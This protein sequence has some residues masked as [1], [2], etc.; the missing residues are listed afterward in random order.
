MA[1]TE[2][3]GLG[4]GDRHFRTLAAPGP[5]VSKGLDR[6]TRKGIVPRP[7]RPY[8]H[9]TRKGIVPCPNRPYKHWT[10]K[11]HFTRPKRPYKH[12]TRTGHFTRSSRPYKHWTRTGQ[13]LK[14]SD[15]LGDM[16]TTGWVTDTQQAGSQIQH[17]LCQRYTTGR[18]RG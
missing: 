18:V 13:L 8:K 17:R 16:Y 11:R 3:P 15:P 4:R 14:A 10:R 5:D 7:R 2:R 12:W 6:H 9:W 1:P